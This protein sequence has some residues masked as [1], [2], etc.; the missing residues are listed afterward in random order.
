[1]KSLV[2][3]VLVWIVLPST[4]HAAVIIN[5]V[6]WMGDSESANNEWIELY[7]TGESQSLAGWQLT[8]GTNLTIDLSGTLTAGTYGVLERT[9]DSS[10]PGTAFLVYT[11]ALAN[12]GATLSLL[13]SDGSIADRVAGGADWELLGGDNTTKDTAQYTSGGWITAAPTPGRVNET[14]PS[15]VV[16]EASQSNESATVRTSS[17]QNGTTQTS[18]TVT[19]LELPDVE[20]QLSVTLPEYIYVNQPVTLTVEPSGLGKTWLDSLQ[21]D[22]NFGDL[23]V[24]TGQV[25]THIYKHPGEYIVTVRA[26]FS[27]HEQ[28]V[29]FPVTVLPMNVS[30]EETVAGDFMVRN[31]A[32]YEVDLSSYTLYGTQA[33][34]FP[35]RTYVAPQATII[36]SRSQVRPLST[37]G[38][39][40]F[41][42]Q[43]N[44]VL[45]FNESAPVATVAEVRTPLVFVP[46][47][48]TEPPVAAVETVVS[49]RFSF[50]SE[51]VP[52]TASPLKAATSSAELIAKDSPQRAAVA[53]ASTTIP[54]EAYPYLGLLGLLGI[55]LLAIYTGQKR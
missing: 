8:D 52:T 17:Q 46:P 42:S 38:V 21:Y 2:V 39:R 19:T 23:S 18:R 30:I 49:N 15:P 5:E 13:R 3:A 20:L 1:M 43:Q 55:G 24:G 6:A 53:D 33:V 10:A 29:K 25:P 7:N 31:N 47:P 50:G 34:T 22:W 9:D 14:T 27:R 26:A 54:R 4:T 28:I 36:I 41:D 40:L 45:T 35:E 16:A 32:Q 48:P 11:G 51:A 44:K 12:T 37:L